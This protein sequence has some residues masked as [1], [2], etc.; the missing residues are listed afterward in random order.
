MQVRQLEE[1][2]GKLWSWN[3]RINLTRH[4]DYEKFVTRDLTDSMALAELLR[5][6]E[7]VLDVG[8]GGGVPGIVLGILRPDLK[9]E[10]CDSTGKK[11]MAVS[12]IVQELRLDIP[13]FHSKAADLLQQQGRR[14]TTLTIRAVSKLAQ[15]LQHL[16]PCWS[17]F[18][19]LLLVKGPNW[20][21]ERGEARHYNLTTKLA[22]RVAKKYAPVIADGDNNPVDGVESVILQLCLKDNLKTLDDVI[23]KHITGGLKKERKEA[24]Y[25]RARFSKN[26]KRSSEQRF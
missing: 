1:Y 18:D 23:D 8:T 15:L 21:A 25:T 24:I 12:E 26:K 9:I 7:R 20:I 16:A 2:C 14:Y 19:R 6:G 3:E 17:S 4:T 10:L 11:T 22:L 5:R 13:V